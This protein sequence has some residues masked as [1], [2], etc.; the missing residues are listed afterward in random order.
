MA[1]RKGDGQEKTFFRRD[2]E[3]AV[4]IA[5]QREKEFRGE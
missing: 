4:R 1:Q 2:T 3:S 5:M